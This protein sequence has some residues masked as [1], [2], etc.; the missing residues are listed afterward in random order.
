VIRAVVVV[1]GG[2]GRYCMAVDFRVGRRL[3]NSKWLGTV[4]AEITQSRRGHVMDVIAIF[5]SRYRVLTCLTILL[6]SY[7]L[8]RSILFSLQLIISTSFEDP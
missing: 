1:I 5:C 4:S 8:I 3:Q 2:V 7:E 6:T